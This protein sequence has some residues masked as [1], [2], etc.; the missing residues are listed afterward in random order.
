MTETAGKIK[1]FL[2]TDKIWVVLFS[3]IV[4]H[5]MN[6]MVIKSNVEISF[7]FFTSIISNEDTTFRVLSVREIF[8]FISLVLVHFEKGFFW[9]IFIQHLHTGLQGNALNSISPQKTGKYCV[10]TNFWHYIYIYNF[11][12]HDFWHSENQSN[13]NCL[14]L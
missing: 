2:Q 3:N 9:F 13:F 5:T 11:G 8:I 12:Q 1:L 10:Y 7:W 6:P 14:P 4:V